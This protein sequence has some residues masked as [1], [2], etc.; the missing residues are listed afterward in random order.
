MPS[1]PA[2]DFRFGLAEV[3]RLAQD[4]ATATDRRTR[5][6]PGPTPDH[7]GVQVD[8]GPCL[9]LV[10][11]DGVYLMSTNKAALTDADG[12]LPVCYAR[13][14]DP[15]SGDWRSAWN[16]TGLAGDDFV[17]YLEVRD[18]GLL[19]AIRAAVADGYDWFV[20]TLTDQHLTLGFARSAG[21]T[22]PHTGD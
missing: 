9:M 22:A 21:S 18:S 8:A 17:E 5:W 19:D 1:V 7:S 6:E 10:R 11:D 15:R 12:R 4:A 14:F 13:G 20:V 16:S 2:V 3:L